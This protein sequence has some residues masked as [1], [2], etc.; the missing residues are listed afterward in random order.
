MT[1]PVV[2]FNGKSFTIRSV[3]GKVL[4]TTTRA[5]TEVHG[6]GGGG[7]GFSYN[8]TG[9]SSAAPIRITSTTTRFTKIFLLDRDQN[10][11]AL[12][13]INFDVHCR[14]GNGLTLVWVI[15]PGQ[16]NGDFI[17]AYNHNTREMEF[18]LAKLAAL[19]TPK[20]LSILAGF[21]GLTLLGVI[22]GWGIAAGFLGAIGIFVGAAVGKQIG[23]SRAQ[24]FVAGPEMQGLRSQ[25]EQIPASDLTVLSAA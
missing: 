4:D 21:G 3:T 24:A 17:A 18:N 22:L 1:N 11:H 7:G 2:V 25:F 5:E 13:L 6:G 8:G 14:A 12:Q 23:K 15:Q 16:D 9:G 10:E 19:N 20:W